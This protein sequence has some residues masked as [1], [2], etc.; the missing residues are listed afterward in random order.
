MGAFGIYDHDATEEAFKQYLLEWKE[1]K[2]KSLR[3]KPTVGSPRM[4]GQSNDG[5]PH[6]ID[7]GMARYVD[8]KRECK[9]REDCCKMLMSIS[10]DDEILGDLLNHR[11]I[12]R[13]SPAKTLM[14]LNDKYHLCMDD[15]EFRRKQ[16]YALWEGAMICKD[17]SVRISKKQ[18]TN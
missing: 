16:S 4:D 7:A 17:G 2:I 11:F 6:D 5:T 9:L 8:D 13:W 18:V 3:H 14:Y 12:K 15:R 10:E 1:Y